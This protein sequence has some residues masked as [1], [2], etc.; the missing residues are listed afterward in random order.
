MFSF[1]V[2]IRVH[3]VGHRLRVQAAP[4]AVAGRVRHHEADALYAHVAA[5]RP[6]WAGMAKVLSAR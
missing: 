1:A 2:E 3:I 4:G 6:Q 5:V